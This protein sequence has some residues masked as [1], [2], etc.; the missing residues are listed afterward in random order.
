MLQVRGRALHAYSGTYAAFLRERAAREVAAANKRAK[1]DAQADKLEG[2][3]TRF[4]AKASKARRPRQ[5]I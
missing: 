4:G 1:L 5:R 3:I 2:F